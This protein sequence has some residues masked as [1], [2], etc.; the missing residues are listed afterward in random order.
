MGWSDIGNFNAL[1]DRSP[2]DGNGNVLIGDVK[3]P[4]CR[5]SYIRAVDGRIC[6]SGLDSA[7]V[8]KAEGEV[9]VCNMENVQTVGQLAGR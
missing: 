7:V 8:V 5:N 2:K 4:G 3:A 9:M 1:W 6:V